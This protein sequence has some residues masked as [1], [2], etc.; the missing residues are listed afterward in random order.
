MYVV[1][2]LHPRDGEVETGGSLEAH[3]P[4]SEHYAVEN[5]EPCLNQDGR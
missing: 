3:G 1:S 2:V 5:K 4:A